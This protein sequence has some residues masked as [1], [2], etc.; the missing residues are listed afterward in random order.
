LS[1]RH[2]KRT[3]AGCEKPGL[4]MNDE[5]V[6][7]QWLIRR[8]KTNLTSIRW[9]AGNR[10]NPLA[11]TLPL[12][13]GCNRDFGRVLEDPVS[14]IFDDLESHRGISENEAELLIRWLWKI[15]GLFWIASYPEGD[16]SRKYTLREK[17]LSPIDI[18]RSYLRLA[19]SLIDHIDECFKDKPIGIDSHCRI[20]GLFV[21]GV[22]SQ[23]AIMV[24]H[25]QLESQIP[26]QY[27]V[28]RMQRQPDSSSNAKLFYPITGFVD[29]TQ[30]VTVSMILGARLSTAHDAFSYVIERQVPKP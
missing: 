11:A 15:D 8:T 4:E 16:Y 7:P 12:C 13:V 17:V 22:F 23:T 19:V 30:A 1:F 21:A 24:V 29:D 14:R 27:S 2:L 3:C 6:F 9:L 28:L 25:E 10:V 5:H 20:D 18:A 26:K